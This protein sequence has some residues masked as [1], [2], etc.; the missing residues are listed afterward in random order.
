MAPDARLV[1]ESAFKSENYP[2]GIVLLEKILIQQEKPA[3]APKKKGGK[4]AVDPITV[5]LAAAWTQVQFLLV[6][7]SEFSAK[8]C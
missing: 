3:I 7:F 5:D 6:I 4:D 1:G 2:T 8:F